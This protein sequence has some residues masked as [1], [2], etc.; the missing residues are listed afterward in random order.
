MPGK[1]DRDLPPP[2]VRSYA[3]LLKRKPRGIQSAGLASGTANVD[4][5][6][7]D[8][9]AVAAFS[10][11][12]PGQ[13]VRTSPL[14]RGAA[15]RSLP[16]LPRALRSPSRGCC[17]G[18]AAERDASAARRP[19]SSASPREALRPVPPV[20][21]GVR[22]AAVAS[23]SPGAPLARD[24]AAG[25]APRRKP[26]AR[27]RQHGREARLQEEPPRSRPAPRRQTFP[28]GRARPRAQ[29]ARLLPG[30][31]AQA[32]APGP[33]GDG[34][35]GARRGL[36][37][38]QRF[39]GGGPEGAGGARIAAHAGRPAATTTPWPVPP[40]P[41][42]AASAPRGRLQQARGDHACGGGG[43]EEA[44]PASAAPRRAARGGAPE[45]AT[46]LS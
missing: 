26:G 17:R 42:D 18:R 27:L 20:P 23:R 28:G 1:L 4:R 32:P 30:R 11:A 40:R 25:A 14:C 3:R 6:C 39:S 8:H 45:A 44:P 24:A 31:R 43:G 12:K 21:L 19:P 7:S 41:G 5:S 16:D 35:D 29:G 13:P 34:R 10:L 36:V 33:R 22:G 15:P 46:A 9:E 2:P 37:G 38:W